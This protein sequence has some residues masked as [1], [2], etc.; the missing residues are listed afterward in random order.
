MRPGDAWL[1]AP[2]AWHVDALPAASDEDRIIAATLRQGLPSTD[3]RSY[4]NDEKRG[5]V[6]VRDGAAWRFRSGARTADG[7]SLS[8]TVKLNDQRTRALLPLSLVFGMLDGSG[9]DY[10]LT[11]DADGWQVTGVVFTW[12]S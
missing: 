5:G 2:G 7:P 3:E 10:V 11:R 4:F 9:Y 6:W 12:V 8:F 1:D